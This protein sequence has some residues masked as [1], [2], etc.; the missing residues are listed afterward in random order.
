MSCTCG[1]GG[2]LKCAG[3]GAIAYCGKPHQEAHA[4]AHGK[5]CASLKVA[6]EK[7]WHKVVVQAGNGERPVAGSL[8]DL[9]YTGQLV[10]GKVFDSSRPKKRTVRAGTFVFPESDNSQFGFTLGQ[11]EVIASWDQGV[12]AMTTGEQ[13]VL[14]VRPDHGYGEHG[15][16]GAIPPNAFLI[17]DCELVSWSE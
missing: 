6:A 12:A 2:S 7:G 4:E 3:C 16:G 5:H 17:F 1:K 13:C 8:C 10:N 14:Y 11:G 9:H 15:A